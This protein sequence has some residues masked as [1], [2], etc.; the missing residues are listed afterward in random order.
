M[1]QASPDVRR[2]AGGPDDSR[3]AR[4][5][6]ALSLEQKVRLLTG[7]SFWRTAAEPAVGLGSMLLSDGP[8]G[9]RGEFWDERRPSLNLP[10][11][12]SLAATWDPGFAERY[13]VV[14]AHEARARGV[15]VVLGP[16]VNLHRS[17][18]GG[19]HFECFSE[20]PTLSGVLAVGYVRGVQRHGVAAVPKHYV[21]NDSETDRYTV[22]VR[23]DERTLRELYLAPFE[24]AVVDGGAWGVMSAYNSVNGA[25][26]TENDLL[27]S[28]LDDEWGFDGFVVS[29]WTAVQST[30][31][32]ARARQDLAMPGPNGPWGERLVAAVL[33]GRVPEAA[34]DLKVARLLRLAARVGALAG[35]EPADTPQP[36]V[37][38][39]DF[40]RE[41]AAAGAVLLRNH[42]GELPWR[43]GDLGSVA[44]SGQAAET[45]RTQGG[46]SATVIPTALVTP[47]D[48]LRAALPGARVAY[49]IG[50]VISDAPV[51]LPL[52][53]LTNPATGE[54]GVRARFLDAD[55][56]ELLVEDRRATDLLWF[57]GGAAG[58]H[59]LELTTRY[60]PASGGPTR[61]AVASV[62]DTTLYVEGEPVVEAHFGLH[63]GLGAGLFVP[64]TASGETTLEAGREVELRVVHDLTSRAGRTG[65]VSLAFGLLPRL[66][67][68][69][70]AIARA[71]GTARDAD[72]AVVVVGTT[73]RAETEGRDRETLALP[74]RQDDL[75][76]AVAAA[77]P[78]TVV[79]VNAGGP[80]LT[81]WRD[82]VAAVLLT[83]FPGQEFGAAL[84]ELLLG[85]REP[86]GRLPTTW[87][88]E[89]A[90]VPVIETRPDAEGRLDYA[91]GP[92]VGYRAWLRAGRAPAY[93][94][95]HG[96]G[97]TSWR[98]DAL[99]L[100][101]RIAAGADVTA[102]VRVTNTGPRAGKQV[103]QL[104]L[105]RRESALDRPVRWLAGFATVH[106]DSGATEDVPV[107]I[108][109]RAFAH[110]DG[111]GWSHEPGVFTAH[112]GTA[113]DALPLSREVHLS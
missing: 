62:G 48:G 83:W 82:E 110:W 12:T 26:M 4:L 18:L 109:G 81:P 61:L 106:L 99:T 27:R 13:G 53:A 76:R 77:N 42:G 71:A 50:A 59:T 93:A 74:G 52:H 79:V 29:D 87:P 35:A 31:A 86:G 33:A 22:D 84:A 80:V 103:V 64:P 60:R 3:E 36:P 20:D 38:P 19:R 98:L 44:V 21:A 89:Q 108:P 105:S 102:T 45:P 66:A 92:H 28:P 113:S 58:G 34:I 39:A 17:P 85:V 40:A 46:G 104:Y 97:Y 68:P 54:P 16:T 9:V 7:A 10:S 75:V 69:D 6:A 101:D 88:A 24:A 41:A 96:L 23:I 107:A 2:P 72:V 11:A 51:P 8:S 111:A 32:S 49:D 67:D 47:L 5:V 55:G 65:S 57:G 90:D 63:D 100:P 95:G 43:A 94:F 14:L 56:A 78:R 70:A 30:E 91:E 73:D 25:T 15:H 1:T 37:P 112:A